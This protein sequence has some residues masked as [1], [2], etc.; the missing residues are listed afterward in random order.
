MDQQWLYTAKVIS[1]CFGACLSD[2]IC[3]VSCFVSPRM[4]VQAVYASCYKNPMVIHYSVPNMYNCPIV[5][6]V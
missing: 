2:S 3:T 6:C 1:R 5:L 4:K